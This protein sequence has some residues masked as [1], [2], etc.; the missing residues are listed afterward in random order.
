MAR[1]NTYETD[2]VIHGSD[3]VIGTDGSGLNDTKNF[4]VSKLAEYFGS[5][6]N[7]TPNTGLEAID[8]GGRNG[9]LSTDAPVGYRIVGR[10]PGLYGNIGMCKFHYD[11]SRHI[12]VEKIDDI[13]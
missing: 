5:A 2:D 12:Y 4:T 1:I 3:K 13:I 10:D 9:Y 11:L 7:F 6:L 8:E